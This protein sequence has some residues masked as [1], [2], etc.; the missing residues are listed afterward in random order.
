MVWGNR[1][2]SCTKKNKQYHNFRNYIPQ[3]KLGMRFDLTSAAMIHTSEEMNA[4]Y[5][6]TTKIPWGI[7][8]ST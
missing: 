4:R 2:I 1:E 6:P 7:K 8:I 3:K 5:W